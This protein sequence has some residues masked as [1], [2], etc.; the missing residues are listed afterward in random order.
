VIGR[1]QD[2][3]GLADLLARRASGLED[4]SAPPCASDLSAVRE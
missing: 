4:E 1:E 2:R 3:D